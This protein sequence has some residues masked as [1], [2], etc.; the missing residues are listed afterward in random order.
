MTE[1]ETM[2]DPNAPHLTI[3]EIVPTHPQGFGGHVFEYQPESDLFRCVN[4][5]CGKYELVVRDSNTGVIE[6]CQGVANSS[7]D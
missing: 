4:D 5:G 3:T 6:P 2:E 7:V 1:G